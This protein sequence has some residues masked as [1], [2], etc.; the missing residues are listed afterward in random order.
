[1]GAGSQEGRSEIKSFTSHRP[2]CDVL[3]V[4]MTLR[5]SMQMKFR[6]CDSIPASCDQSPVFGGVSVS[7]CKDRPGSLHLPPSKMRKGDGAVCCLQSIHMGC[8]PLVVLPFEAVS[9]FAQVGSPVFAEIAH[10]PYPALAHLPQEVRAMFPLCCREQQSHG[11]KGR[12]HVGSMG[13][14]Q[15]PVSSV[16]ASPMTHLPFQQLEGGFKRLELMS[17]W[18]T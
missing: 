13:F 15:T 7:A 12:M 3:C 11:N 1:M 18:T 16:C 6:V 4:G 2:V 5:P 14:G 10:L 17:I 8:L 9:L